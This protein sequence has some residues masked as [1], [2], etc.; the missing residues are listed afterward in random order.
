MA[1]PHPLFLVSVAAKGL[2]GRGVGEKA[3]GWDGKILKA[4]E[5]GISDPTDDW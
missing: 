2:T 3:I 5:E 1:E 4:A